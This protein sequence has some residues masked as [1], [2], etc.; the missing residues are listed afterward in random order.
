MTRQEPHT[1][2]VCGDLFYVPQETLRTLDIN[3]NQDDEIS[4]DLCFNCHEKLLKWI[5]NVRAETK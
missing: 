3:R 5:L 1:C 4:Y 2:D